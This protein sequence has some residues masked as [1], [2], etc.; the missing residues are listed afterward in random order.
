[1]IGRTLTP[2]FALAVAAIAMIATPGNITAQSVDLS[3]RGV[4]LSVGGVD[5]SVDGNEA[6]ARIELAGSVI[7]SLTI[8]FEQVVGLSAQ[9]LGLSV[10]QVNPLSTNLL[11]SLRDVTNISVPSG[12]PLLITVEPPSN[13]GLSFE[14][15]VE[16]EIY[17]TALH[18]TPGTS[19]RLFKSHD[20]GPFRDITAQTAAGSYRVRGSSGQW[21]SL[22]ILADTRPLAQTISDKFDLLEG[23]L[24]AAA[25][26]ID[27]ATLHN[28]QMLFD[29]AFAAWLIDDISGA[30]QKLVEFETT[31]KSA[32]A[33]GLVP[34]V[35]RSAR[36]LDNF[37]GMLRT[38]AGTLRFSLGLAG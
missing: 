25:G 12:F 23:E 29:Q 24:D 11:G 28:L 14:G 26:Q 31:V 7:A 4:D 17:T 19:L 33:A 13:G 37:D 5:L 10:S 9:S 32:A 34:N 20:N 8:R 15:T 1:M 16:V 6:H 18:Y 22:M 30:I 2:I 21:S 35:W 38:R 36:D 3:V 27:S